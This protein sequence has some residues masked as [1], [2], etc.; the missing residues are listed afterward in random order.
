VFEWV[1]TL[2]V[3]LLLLAACERKPAPALA[4]EMVS[5]WFARM[6]AQLQPL[7]RQRDS[8]AAILRRD[9][10]TTTADSLFMVF[11]GRYASGID[12]I[13]SK[14]WDDAPFQNW[15]ISSPGASD[16]AER[17]FEARGFRLTS[18]EGSIY[19]TVN[20]GVLVRTLKPFLTPALKDF[21]ALRKHDEDQRFSN[22]AALEI[23]WDSVSERV[24][25]W[26][27][28]LNAH[29]VF[30]ARQEA[31][32]WYSLYLST[33]LTGMDNSP[34]FNDTLVPPLRASYQRFL[35]LHGDT[36]AGRLVRSYLD[37]LRSTGFR[38]APQ[39]AEFLRANH[40]TSMAAV[41]P[42]VR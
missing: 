1:R 31:Q 4:P 17:F 11:R 2:L 19:P 41:Q 3:L 30:A 29:P 10:G 8:V 16:S 5:P 34:V 6:D 27:R 38:S 33:Y 42:P 13:A 32:E 20:T 12:S 7:L 23:P 36:R 37:V 21:L 9:S 15:L 35:R 40:V 25:A 26:D 24:A 39:V 28:L 22:D 14:T 18:E